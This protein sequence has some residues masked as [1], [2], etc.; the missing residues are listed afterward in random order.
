MHNYATFEMVDYY[1]IMLVGCQE[2][3]GRARKT[4]YIKMNMCR[5]GAILGIVC[6]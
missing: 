5:G 3:N 4:S 2:C 6:Q 1:A